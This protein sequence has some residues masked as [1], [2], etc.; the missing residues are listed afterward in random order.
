MY[1][2]DLETHEPSCVARATKSFFIL[3]IHSLPDVVRHVTAPELPSQKDR[4]PSRE[5]RDSN[6][7]FRR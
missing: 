3:M 4:A 6:G 2:R 1:E 7:S 5:I